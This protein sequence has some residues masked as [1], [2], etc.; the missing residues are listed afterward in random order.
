MVIDDFDSKSNATDD[1]SYDEYYE[2]DEDETS[3]KNDADDDD[4]YLDDYVES[5][6]DLADRSPPVRKLGT[7]AKVVEAIGNCDTEKLIPPECRFDTD[8]PGDLKCCEVA[9]GRRMCNIP[10]KR[11]SSNLFFSSDEDASLINCRRESI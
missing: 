5:L 2:Y 4:E 1:S 3:D 7:C 11:K 10:L 6:D 9:C 8:C